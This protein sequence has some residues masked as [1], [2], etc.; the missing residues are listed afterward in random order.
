MSLNKGKALKAHVAEVLKNRGPGTANWL[1]STEEGGLP[2]NSRW[3]TID[4]VVKGGIFI[5]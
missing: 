5:I 1:K 3:R 2:L 4:G